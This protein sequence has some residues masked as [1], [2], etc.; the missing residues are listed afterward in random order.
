MPVIPPAGF[1]ASPLVLKTVSVA[2]RFGRIF[3]A[4]YLDPLGFGKTASRFSDPRPL[5][6]AERFGVLYVGATLEVCFLEAF[7]RDRRDGSVGDFPVSERELGLL[8]Y[9]D[10]SV[11]ASLSLV[12]LTGVAAIR[13]GIPTDVAHA[14]NQALARQWSVALHA[15]PSAPDGIVYRSRLNGDLNL[16]IFE[17]AL[18]KL[19]VTGITSLIAA[20]GLATIIDKLGASLVD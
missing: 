4:R 19:S 13:M 16:A 1:D 17:R 15:H 18:G 3:P 20:P 6:E 5:P 7:V 12:D 9:A 2:E 11:A 14:A 8:L 10:I